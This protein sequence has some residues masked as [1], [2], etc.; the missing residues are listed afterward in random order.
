MATPAQ[1]TLYKP[2]HCELA[3]NYCLLGATNDVLA[4]R[5]RPVRAGMRHAGE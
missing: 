4:G 3:H 2:E 1:P 5:P